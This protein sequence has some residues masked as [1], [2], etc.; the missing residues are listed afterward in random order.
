MAMQTGVDN[1]GH[2]F[3]STVG[4]VA[5]DEECYSL[6]ADLM[7]PIIE[8]RH[9]GFKKT[10]KHVT[11]L[12]ASKIKGGMLDENYVLSSRVRTGR[13]IKGHCLPPHCTRAERRS[14]EYI[15]TSALNSLKGKFIVCSSFN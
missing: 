1:P 12:D 4:V 3:I 5:G 9:N 10:D 15:L 6:L 2:P 8:D 7:D 13:S 11:D 14:V